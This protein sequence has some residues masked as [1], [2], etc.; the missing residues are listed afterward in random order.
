M[1][2]PVDPVAVMGAAIMNAILDANRDEAGG[3]VVDSKKA[4][5]ALVVSMAMILEAEPGLRTPKEVREASEAIARDLR[6]Q[7]RGLRAAYEATGRRAWDATPI[8]LN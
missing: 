6:V 7:Y 1:S 2:Q 5:Q 8:G 3:A 4:V